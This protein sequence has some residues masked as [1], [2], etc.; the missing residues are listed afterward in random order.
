[1]GAQFVRPLIAQSCT[2]P[3]WCSAPDS[4][5]P[6]ATIKAMTMQAAMS[7]RREP[8]LSCSNAETPS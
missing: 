1:M 7:G 8:S 3:V 5:S 2:L 6:A 4:Q